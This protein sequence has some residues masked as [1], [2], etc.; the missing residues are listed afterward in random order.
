MIVMAAAM[1]VM[2]TAMIVVSAM[3]EAVHII[4]GRFVRSDAAVLRR[5]AGA[6]VY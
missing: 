3:S 5:S 2:P 6:S 4:L 1:V